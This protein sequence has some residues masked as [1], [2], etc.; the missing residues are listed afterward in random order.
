MSRIE[1]SQPLQVIWG[2]QGSDYVSTLAWSPDASCL[3]GKEHGPEL[4]D[5]HIELAIRER[6]L[7]RIRLAPLHRSGCS[8]RMVVIERGLIQVRRHDGASVGQ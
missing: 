1:Q 4:A 5:D 2:V 8:N 3:P 7:H 6:Q